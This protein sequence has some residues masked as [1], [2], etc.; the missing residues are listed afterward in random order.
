MRTRKSLLPLVI[1]LTILL[2]GVVFTPVLG[3]PQADLSWRTS[4]Q[5][6]PP[7]YQAY[8]YFDPSNPGVCCSVYFYGYTNPWVD[9]ATYSWDFGDGTGGFGQSLSHRYAADGDYLA[10]LTVTTPDGGSSTYSQTVPVH[11][12]AYFDYYPYDPSAYD[13]VS[14]NG[15]I[16]S[17]WG[18][19]SV[20]YVWDFGDGTTAEGQ[21]A[22][23]RFPADGDY[24]VTLTAIV[25]GNLTTSTSRTVMVRTHDVAI[26][27]FKVP[28][29]AKAGQT[30][31]ITV[32]L[33]NKNYEEW[34]NVYLYKSQPSYGFQQVGWLRQVVPPRGGNRTT[35]FDF[36]Y[37]FT[38]DDAAVGKVTFRAEAS[39][40]N[41]RDALPADNQA[42]ADPTK[43][44]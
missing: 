41:A 27:S 28:E 34:V 43:V 5:M 31:N 40:E 1:V 24:E 8:F 10:M 12:Q 4:E 44:N 38:A 18:W 42:V 32:G 3:M 15:Y 19:C 2:S 13:M 11:T 22:Q 35:N 39:T 21:Y 37:T 33:S 30:R 20:A 25:D 9:Y 16:N 6:Y 26:I 7:Y 14:F 29:S 17:N 36:S 23:H